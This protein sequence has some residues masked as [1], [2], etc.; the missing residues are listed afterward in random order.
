[1]PDL[2]TIE[3][4]PRGSR[5]GSL[6]ADMNG[7]QSN[8]DLADAPAVRVSADLSSDSRRIALAKA[9]L[10]R[11]LDCHADIPSVARACRLSVGG[12]HR[13]FRD[14]TGLPP[15][16]WLRSLRIE[17]AKILLAEGALS[18]ADI[19][20]CC[21]F[22]DQSHFTRTFAHVS[23]VAPGRWRRTHGSMA[24]A[25]DGRSRQDGG[26]PIRYDLVDVPRAFGS[27]VAE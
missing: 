5:V 27:C 23:G 16:R 15:L 26:P 11:Q 13:A 20:V 7:Q 8:P 4:R 6:G 17:T 2:R 3:S 12:F 24:N 25:A 9:L 1:M 10:A 21:G 14:A 22:A 19:A 18:L